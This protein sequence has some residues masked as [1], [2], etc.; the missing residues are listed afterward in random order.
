MNLE[1]TE[2]YV[3]QPLPPQ[4]DGKFYGVGGLVS[5]GLSFDEASL[6]GV[7]KSDAEEIVRVVTGSPQFAASFVRGV[8]KSLNL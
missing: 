6:Q 3:Y 5:Y 7:T 2:A 1:P 4:E 8:K